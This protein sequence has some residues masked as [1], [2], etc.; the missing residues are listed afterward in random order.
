MLAQRAAAYRME[1]ACPADIEINVTGDYLKK[2]LKSFSHLTADE[3]AYIFA[4]EEFHYSLIDF[5][6]FR[7]HASA[8][9]LDGRAFLFSAPSGTGKSTHTSLWCN[10]FGDA[11][12]YILN[13]DTPVIKREGDRFIAY[14]TPW[15]GTSPLNKNVGVPLESVAFL[16]R[17]Q[18]NWI[19]LATHDEGVI[20]IMTQTIKTSDQKCMEKLL[21]LLGTFLKE[22]PIFRMGCTI[23]IQAVEMAH[24]AMG[25]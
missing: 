12:T 10:Y 22:V 1:S 24:A 4:G 20:N 16:E 5:D 3:C 14:G 8:V 19:R 21:S 23:S 25:R 18:E 2:M 17:S 7:L 11:R 15:S 9:V 6:C 13:D